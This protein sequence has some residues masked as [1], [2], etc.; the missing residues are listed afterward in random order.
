MSPLTATTTMDSKKRKM[1]TSASAP[2][3][4]KKTKATAAAEKNVPVVA[5]TPVPADAPVSTD[6]P[7]TETAVDRP[8]FIVKSGL[9]NYFKKNNMRQNSAV[10]DVLTTKVEALIED[11]FKRA[12]QNNR[13]TVMPYDL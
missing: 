6:A 8:T 10:Y 5:D 13:C 12:K 1:Q 2:K 3:K 4:P 7:V 9:A 11:A